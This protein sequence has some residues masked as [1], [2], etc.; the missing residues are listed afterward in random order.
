MQAHKEARMFTVELLA[1]IADIEEQE[2]LRHGWEAM[3]L[4]EPVPEGLPPVQYP[5]LAPYESDDLSKEVDQS[6]LP[7]TVGETEVAP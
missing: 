5:L 7:V 3:L 6:W 2:A 4:P 1:C